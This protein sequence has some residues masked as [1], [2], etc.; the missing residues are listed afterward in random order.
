MCSLTGVFGLE[1]IV[2]QTVYKGAFSQQHRGEDGVGLAATNGRELFCKAD[3]GLVSEK[4]DDFLR[5]AG[6]RLGKKITAAIAHTRYPTEGEVTADNAQPFWGET[7]HGKIAFGHNGELTNFKQVRERLM[8]GGV[9]LTKSSDSE[10]FL[11]LYAQSEGATLLER[12][13]NA[14]TPLKGAY[15][16]VGIAEG[17]LFAIRDPHGIKPLS[18]AK[19]NGGYIISSETAAFLDIEGVEWIKDVIP[20]TALTIDHEGMKERR[21]AEAEKLAPCIF[22][23]VYFARPDSHIAGRNVHLV[24]EE[25]GKELYR[26]RPIEADMVI[27]IED[28]GRSAAEGFNE[29]SDI[30]LKRG[31]IRNHYVGR[32]FT[33]PS[34]ILRGRGVNLKLSPMPEVIRGK[35]VVVIDDSI[36]R[37]R[38]AASRVKLLRQAGAREVHLYIS[39]PKIVDNCHYGIDFHREQMRA[40]TNPDDTLFLREIGADSLVHLTLDNMFKAIERVPLDPRARIEYASREFCTG[41][42]NSCY[43]MPPEF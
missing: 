25:F 26:Q 43:P 17:K 37:G 1:E 5:E 12:L 6:E 27:A 42:L 34:D 39:S 36:V 32:T 9:I 11:P 8:R 28:S 31:F 38:T 7:R 19:L 41:C 23:H 29:A 33:R 20:G 21:F 14:A 24:R 18:V 22:E 35:R 15:C 13:G 2:E 40:V 30:P 3:L 4:I 16:F 10:V